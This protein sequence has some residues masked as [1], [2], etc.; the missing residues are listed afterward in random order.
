MIKKINSIKQIIVP[1]K[2]INYFVISLLFLGVILGAVFANIIGFN[3]K[4]LVIDKIKTFI[5]N[6]NTASI[7]SI[8]AF[9][10]SISTNLIYVIVI[11]ILG[12]TG[13]GILFS[14]ILLIAKSFI[15]G[16]SLASFIITYNYKGII[17]S[18][19]YLI[20]GQLLN[21]II[22]TLLTIYGIMFTGKLFKLIFK[23]QGNHDILNFFK[24][25]LIIL[26]FSIIIS[27]ISSSLEVFA[28][29][30]IIKLIINLFI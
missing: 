9:R 16:F 24:N 29:P 1:T 15:F 30:A 18:F 14:I 25:Y 28:L 4:T 12:M 27:F 22:I 6:I 5:D 8:T 10:N 7:N 26:V 20:F 19:L 13:L 2:K 3:D 11:F 17:L 21:I 23:N